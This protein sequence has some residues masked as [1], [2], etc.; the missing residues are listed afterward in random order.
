VTAGPLVGDSERDHLRLLPA[1]GDP[2]AS[3][4]SMRFVVGDAV[5]YASH[6]IGR[7]ESLRPE[8]GAAETITVGFPSGLTVILPLERA[9]DALRAPA[10]EAELDDVRSTLRVKTDAALEPWARRNRRTR[11]KVISGRAAELAEVVRDG[12][13][14]ELRR[15]ATGSGTTSPSDRQ[16]Y[17]QAHALLSAEIAFC[18]DIE[19]SDAEA[20]ILDQVSAPSDP[21]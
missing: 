11:E 19:Q 16:L 3:E 6:G 15:A 4:E 20:W 5:V 14:R 21:I 10:G 2:A 8:A 13:Q 7:V 18:R 12:L 1:P 17:L 9:H